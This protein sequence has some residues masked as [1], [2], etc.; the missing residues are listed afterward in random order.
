MRATAQKP[1]DPLVELGRT[2][3]EQAFVN[4]NEALRVLELLP[5]SETAFCP[6]PHI[7]VRAEIENAKRYM[8]LMY[9]T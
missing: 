4:L 1:R 2:A 3:M 6:H 7:I 8:R 5:K 9:K